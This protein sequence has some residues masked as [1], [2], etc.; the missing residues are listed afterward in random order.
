MMATPTLTGVE[1]Q[2][3]ILERLDAL[4]VAQRRAQFSDR[5]IDLQ[6]VADFLGFSQAQTRMRI[7]TLPGFPSPLATGHARWLRSEVEAWAQQ[8]RRA[9]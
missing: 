9:P 3:A 6:E 4:L 1:L 5:W 8:H 7:V 2:A